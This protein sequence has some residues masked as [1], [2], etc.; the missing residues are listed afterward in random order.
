MFKIVKDPYPDQE[1][2]YVVAKIHDYLSDENEYSI[3]GFGKDEKEALSDALSRL[4]KN[5][6]KTEDLLDQVRIFLGEN[7]PKYHLDSCTVDL[8]RNI[9]PQDKKE[10]L[11]FSEE[12]KKVGKEYGLN[13]DTRT[14]TMFSEI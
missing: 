9:D 5:N 14:T 8:P 6:K 2:F 13:S 7:D 12:M 4:L 10:V 1:I 3:I 11:E